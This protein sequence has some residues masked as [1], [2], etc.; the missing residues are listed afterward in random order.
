MN[1]MRANSNRTSDSSSL[2]ALNRTI[3][4]L[5][6]RIESLI[7]GASSRQSQRAES[8]PRIEPRSSARFDP[9]SEIRRRQQALEAVRENSLDRLAARQVTPPEN[10]HY[11]RSRDP[12]AAQDLHETLNSLKIDLRNDL[13]ES[14]S[15]EMQSLRNEIKALRNTAETQRPTADL[16]AEIAHLQAS[17]ERLGT[18]RSPEADRLRMDIE[19]LRMA[20]DQMARED[21]LVR[22]E[23]RWDNVEDRLSSIDTNALQDEIMSLAYR[24]DDIKAQLGSHRDSP[25]IVAIEGKLIALAEL[26][27]KLGQHIQ[28]NDQVL[29]DQFAALDERLDEISRAIAAASSRPLTQNIDNAVAQRI[30]SRLNS[31]A[32]HLDTLSEE[33]SRKAASVT[34][35]DF[36][37]RIDALAGRIEDLA[38]QRNV[39]RLEERLEQLSEL[40]ATNQSAAS[41]PE[42]SSF[43]HDISHKIDALDPSANSYALEQRFEQLSRQLEGIDARSQSSHQSP[44]FDSAFAKLEERLGDIVMRL[45]ETTQAGGSDNQAIASLESQIAHLSQLISQPSYQDPG[46]MTAQIDSRMSAIEE[47]IASNDEYIVEVARQAAEAVLDSY[48]RN[49]LQHTHSTADMQMIAGLADDLR[50][51]ENLTKS[52]EARTQQT[53]EALHETL[54]Q[55]ANRLDRLDQ[56]AHETA[57]PSEVKQPFAS[58]RIAQTETSQPAPDLFSGESEVVSSHAI[59]AFLDEGE[60]IQSGPEQARETVEKRGLFKSL[61]N[62]FRTSTSQQVEATEPRIKVDPVPSLDPTDALESETELLEPGSGQP[63]IKQILERVRAAQ[64]IGQRRQP[65]NSENRADIIA[66]ARRAAA[67]AA[68][69]SAQEGKTDERSSASNNKGDEKSGS[70]FRRPLLLG[71][72]AILL[73]LLTIPVVKTVTKGLQE[74][75]TAIELNSPAPSVMNDSFTT[76][77]VMV[78][79]AADPVAQAEADALEAQANSMPPAIDDRVIGGKPLPNETLGSGVKVDSFGAMA[80]SNTPS[81]VDAPQLIEIPSTITTQSLAEAAAKGD[82]IALFEVASRFVEGRSGVTEDRAQAAKYYKIAADKGHAMSQYRLASM[83]EKA[84]GVEQNFSEAQRYYEL[85]ANQGNAGAMHNLAVMLTSNA[86]QTPDFGKAAEWFTKAANLGVGDSQYNLAVLYARGS[87][88]SVDLEEAYKWFAITARD[89]DSDA[90]DKRDQIA[91]ALSPSQLE[92]AKAKFSKWVAQPLNEDTNSVTLPDA[93]TDG[94]AVATASVDMEK[95][96]RNIQAILNKN[97]FDAGTADGKLGQKTVNAIKEFQSSAGMT[98]DG[99]IT[100]QLVT[101]LLKRNK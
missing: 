30:E 59:D 34:L 29:T 50:N 15:R 58:L 52:S 61:T 79:G 11:S 19:D 57:E 21:S 16:T 2:D 51:L 9:V 78:P 17:V 60:T 35:P 45:D 98:A 31:L 89:G 71:I 5:E 37:Q 100:D 80:K 56:R 70:R 22:I 75:Q 1:G 33:T 94:E 44:D 99:K 4:G 88:V 32:E 82:P 68:M 46:S 7:S 77:S 26:V 54:V 14:L 62:K 91:K 39:A 96:I 65:V 12:Y 24:L 53:F 55:I 83:Y 84:N 87:G 74:P 8:S 95:A 28:P 43:L 36:N 63:D 38:N 66:A 23:R 97:G 25:A 3:E 47:H 101:E 6:A 49:Q 73:A 20:V 86:V 40:L 48:L 41:Q 69:E 27:E 67:A 13:S 72:G 10:A 18:S 90:A 92:S 85:A 93:W 64:T 76:S 81:T 42:I